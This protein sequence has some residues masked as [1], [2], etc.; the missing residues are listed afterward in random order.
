[1]TV[2]MCWPHHQDHPESL[3]TIGERI[4]WNGR[5]P[6]ALAMTLEGCS[7]DVQAGTAAV[8]AWRNA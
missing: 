3:H 1:M 5:D 4:F 6:V 7:G 2:P 8:R